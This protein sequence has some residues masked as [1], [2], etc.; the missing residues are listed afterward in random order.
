MLELAATL[1]VGELAESSV[2]LY[3]RPWVKS[4]DFWDVRCDL[5]EKIKLAFDAQ[6]ISIPFPQMDVHWEG[7]G[8]P[9]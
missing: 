8:K 4:T 1:V 6:D 7:A 9:A 2:N 5:I 3:A